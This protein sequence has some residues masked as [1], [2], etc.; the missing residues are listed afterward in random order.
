MF[1][2]CVSNDVVSFNRESYLFFDVDPDSDVHCPRFR[3]KPIVFTSIDLSDESSFMLISL[4]EIK[5][6]METFTYQVYGLNVIPILSASDT[7]ISG[8]FE[9]PLLDLDLSTNLFEELNNCSPWQFQYRY[10][11]EKKANAMPASI[12]FR[13]NN[14]DIGDMLPSTVCEYQTSQMFMPSDKDIAPSPRR[15]LKFEP[16]KASKHLYKELTKSKAVHEIREYVK[17]HLYV[18]E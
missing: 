1:V 2:V 15:D 3:E 8:V 17:Q 12:I 6:Q 18:D 10:L 14:T 7:L 4:I 5:K 16:A 11:K 9:V 13:Q